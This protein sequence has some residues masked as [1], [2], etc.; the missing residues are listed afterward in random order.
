LEF[1]AAVF[2]DGR[3]QDVVSFKQS[4]AAVDILVLAP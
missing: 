3:E 4:K 2:G 1:L